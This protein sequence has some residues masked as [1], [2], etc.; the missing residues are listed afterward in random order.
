MKNL[1]Q[2]IAAVMARVEYIKKDSKVTAGRESYTAVS[3]DAVIAKLRGPMLDAGIVSTVTQKGDSVIFE[4]QT[5]AGTAKIR[6]QALFTVSYVNIDDPSDRLDI[7]IE[8]HAEDMGDKAPGKAASYAVKTAHLKTFSLA[9]GDDDEQRQDAGPAMHT[10]APIKKIDM[11]ETYTKAAAALD[12]KDSEIKDEVRNAIAAKYDGEIPATVAVLSEPLALIARAHLRDL[13][14]AKKEQESA[15]YAEDAA[16]EKPKT[17]EQESEASARRR[18]Q[19]NAEIT[20]QKVDREEVKAGLGK[21]F[22]I[23]STSGL[24][25]LTDGEW[26][27][28]IADLQTVIDAGKEDAADGE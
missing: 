28:V 23:P 8:A 27:S 22:G 5:R 20:K 9:T 26:S 10:A 25:A 18:K 6:F 21:L 4:G 19:I 12:W 3:H 11:E 7:N 24:G 14:K 2:R 16:E 13:F 15:N 17:P 1:Y